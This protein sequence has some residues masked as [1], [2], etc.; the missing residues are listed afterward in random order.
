MTES[1][2][3]RY[4]P[5]LYHIT[6]VESWP[7]ILEHGL[8]STSAILDRFG[9]SGPER[10]EV[11]SCRR[12]SSMLLRHDRF[13]E[14]RL[15]DRKPINLKLLARCLGD[16]ASSDWFRLLNGLVFFWPNGDRLKRH[17]GARLG[18]GRD[19]AVLTFDSAALL[20][21]YGDDLRLSP[22]NSGCT[23]PPQPRGGETFRTLADYPFD[24]IRSR[25]GP[26]KSIA[27]V[28]VLRRVDSVESL[29]SRIQ[30]YGV[31][32]T[33]TTVWAREAREMMK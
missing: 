28:T 30:I 31:N 21:R 15:S 29:A 11:E 8:E 2:F 5:A 10:T 9:I 18:G 23:R 4:F 17:L 1:E 13:P 14:V 12:A 19:Q 33:R 27:E 20:A 3:L 22:L 6:E 7:S 26:T 16:M 24:D 32:G 25:R